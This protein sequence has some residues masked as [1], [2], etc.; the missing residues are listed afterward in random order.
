MKIL[1]VRH[2]ITDLHTGDRFWGRTDMPLSPAGIRQAERLRDRLALEKIDAVYASPLRRAYKTAEIIAAG[3]QVAI[4]ACEDLCECNF[5]EIEGLNF[6][7]IKQ[8]YPALAGELSRRR[9]G[10]FPGGETIEQLNARVLAFLKTLEKH[11]TEETLLVV[12]HGGPVRLL[13]CNLLGLGLEYWIQFRIDYASLSIV[14]TYPGMNILD[15]CNDVSHLK[16]H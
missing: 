9:T 8:R 7:E 10:A 11:R 1:L 16:E 2:G 6:D 15:L 3:H 13:I 14:E 12:A 5:G 4:N